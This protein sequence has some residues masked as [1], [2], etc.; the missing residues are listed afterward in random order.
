MDIE[1][2]NVP[3]ESKKSKFHFVDLAGLEC[4]KKS[5]AE[6][7]QFKEGIEINKG[8]LVPQVLGNIISALS[9]GTKH[10]KTFVPYCDSKLTRLLKGSL[11]G[12]HKMLMIA[13]ISLSSWRKH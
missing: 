11:G 9:D 2:A 13:C 1:D 7:K 3:F 5:L 4:Q 12:N 10:G 6:G 8:L